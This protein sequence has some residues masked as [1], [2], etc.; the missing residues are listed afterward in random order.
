MHNHN[1]FILIIQDRDLLT[2]RICFSLDVILTGKSVS[3]REILICFSSF[4]SCK[5]KQNKNLSVLDVCSVML[6]KIFYKVIIIR[7]ILI[8]HRMNLLYPLLLCKQ[9]SGCQTVCECHA[10]G[11]LTA[12]IL[13]HSSISSPSPSWLVGQLYSFSPARIRSVTA[14]RRA[15]SDRSWMRLALAV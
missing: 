4:C 9:V 7:N 12:R 8:K 5:N 15:R 14:G 2:G 10:L 6:G 1:S 11:W 13:S 3:S